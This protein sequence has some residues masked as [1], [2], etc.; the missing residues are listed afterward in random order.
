MANTG[1]LHEPLFSIGNQQAGLGKQR[2]AAACGTT[3]CAS[4]TDIWGSAKS[5]PHGSARHEAD[6]TLILLAIPAGLEPATP[7]LEGA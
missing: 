6:N 4:R 3:M 2:Q 1:S 5:K 7:S